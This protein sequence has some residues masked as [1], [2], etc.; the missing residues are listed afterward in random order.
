MLSVELLSQKL[1][2]DFI[3]MFNKSKVAMQMCV[4]QNS[5]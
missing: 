4:Y 3:Q 2:I 5:E 1:I